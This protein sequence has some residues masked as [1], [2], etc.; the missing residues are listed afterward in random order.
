MRDNVPRSACVCV[1]CLIGKN[2]GTEHET[3][4]FFKFRVCREWRERER[5]RERERASLGTTVH[6]GG[7]RA[8]PAHGLR[9]TTRFPASPRA[10][11]GVHLMSLLNTS[12]TFIGLVEVKWDEVVPVRQRSPPGAWRCY[13]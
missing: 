12:V 13:S 8:A 6:N 5:E 3:R 1:E 2:H 9:I 10:W 4:A 7:S 11:S